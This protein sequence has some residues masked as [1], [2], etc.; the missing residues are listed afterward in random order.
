M[1]DIQEVNFIT[2]ENAY[3]AQKY[4]CFEIKDFN[5]LCVW[6][7]IKPERT[8]LYFFFLAYYLLHFMHLYY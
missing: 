6:K 7:E 5:L 4:E 2:C 1:Q 3:Y 8:V